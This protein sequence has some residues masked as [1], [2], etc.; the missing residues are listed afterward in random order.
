MK[1]LFVAAITAVFLTLLPAGAAKAAQESCESD[2]G[3]GG[4]VGGG[5][6]IPVGEGARILFNVNYAL[7]HAGGDNVSSIGM[8][9]GCLF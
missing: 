7:K 4:L 6:G 9:A 2:K 1:R 5:Y 8:S 3:Y